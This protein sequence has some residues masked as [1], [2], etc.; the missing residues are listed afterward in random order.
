MNIFM[1][2]LRSEWLRKKRSLASWLV[3]IGGVF[4]PLL[5]TLAAFAY[6]AETIGKYAPQQFWQQ[7]YNNNI[8]FMAFFLLPMG[9]ILATSLITQL[10]HKNNA[11]KLVHTMPVSYA[12]IFFGKLVLILIMMIQFF[13][14]LNIC[15]WLSGAVPALIIKSLSYPTSSFPFEYYAKNSLNYYLALLPVVALQYTLGTLFKNFLIPLGAGIALFVCGLFAMQWE[16]AYT[17]P[18]IYSPLNYLQ[19]TDSAIKT[20]LTLSAYSLIWFMVITISGYF[21][22]IW[23][24][25]KS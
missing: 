22:Y 5:S 9:I 6:P 11:W 2:S 14:L 4:I 17:I 20:P 21:F 3:V 13:V 18:Y 7:V 25:D 24:K 12:T 15:I 10:E 1:H 8:Q 19:Q 23:K 16:Y